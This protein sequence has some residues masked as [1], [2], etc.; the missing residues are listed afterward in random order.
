MSST[1]IILVLIKLEGIALLLN[2][3]VSQMHEQIIYVFRVLTGWL[4]FLCGEAS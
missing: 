1:V 2:S 4:E 3:V